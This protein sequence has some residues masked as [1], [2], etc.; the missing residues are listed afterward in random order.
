MRNSS[1]DQN[2]SQTIS[3]SGGRNIAKHESGSFEEQLEAA[4]RE[5]DIKKLLFDGAPTTLVSLIG[6]NQYRRCARDIYY[7]S[8]QLAYA[9]LELLLVSIFPEMRNVVLSVHENVNV[10]HAS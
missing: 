6:H 1:S 9:I 4:R 5:S 8:Q 2:P 10:H 7:F 3:G